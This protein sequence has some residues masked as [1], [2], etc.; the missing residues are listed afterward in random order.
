MQWCFLATDVAP[1]RKFFG[2]ILLQ[3]GVLTFHLDVVNRQESRWK[4]RIYAGEKSVFSERGYNCANVLSKQ[5][6]IVSFHLC[7][8]NAN[9]YLHT[10]EASTLQN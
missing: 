8:I 6:K 2:D 7:Y 3:N 9:C 4:V 1:R 5:N 10:R